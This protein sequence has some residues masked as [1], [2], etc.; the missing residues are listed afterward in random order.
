MDVG[1]MMWLTINTQM[2]IEYIYFCPVG[3]L[4]SINQ[5]SCTSIYCV[6][7]VCRKCFNANFFFILEKA[8]IVLTF[9]LHTHLYVKVL[10]KLLFALDGHHF[11]VHV[12]QQGFTQSARYAVR[13]Y[14]NSISVGNVDICS[15]VLLTFKPLGF[16]A[17]FTLRMCLTCLRAHMQPATIGPNL[18]ALKAFG[19]DLFKTKGEYQKKKGEG[20]FHNICPACAPKSSSR[21]V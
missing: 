16:C 5:F 4:F 6:H 3:H 12:G 13:C 11:Y 1:M 21:S 15:C 19:K 17:D 2:P 18:N 10:T 7:Y 9:T 14:A 20:K 8:N